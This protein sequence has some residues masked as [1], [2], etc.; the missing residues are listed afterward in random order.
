[1]I[2]DNGMKSNATKR[3]VFEGVRTVM[4]YS[5]SQCT[6]YCTTQSAILKSQLHESSMRCIYSLIVKW[7][8]MSVPVPV[9]VPVYVYLLPPLKVQVSCSIGPSA[10]SP[11]R[12]P[13]P[14]AS[15]PESNARNKMAENFIIVCF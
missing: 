12:E 11:R 1:M 13:E 14:T 2:F 8:L 4:R 7:N 5:N 9:P 3:N 10:S 15:A 6:D